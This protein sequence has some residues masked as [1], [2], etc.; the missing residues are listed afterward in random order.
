MA[1][2]V[3][4]RF[5]CIDNSLLVGD[6]GGFF[7]RHAVCVFYLVLRALDTIEDDMSIPLHTK[8]PMLKEFHTYLYDADWK[9]LTSQEKDKIVLED[10]ITVSVAVSLCERVLVLWLFYY[11]STLEKVPLFKNRA[12]YCFTAFFIRDNVCQ[13]LLNTIIGMF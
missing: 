11:I 2:F 1:R 5:S 9:F 6:V 13:I 4:Q 7:H 3:T 10:F 8:V 12:P